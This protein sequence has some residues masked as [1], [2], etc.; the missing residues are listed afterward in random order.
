MYFVPRDS[1]VDFFKAV[2][3]RTW[4]RVKASFLRRAD[5]RGFTRD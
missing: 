4:E 1:A 5:S 2:S 3:A